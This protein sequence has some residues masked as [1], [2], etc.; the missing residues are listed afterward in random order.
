MAEEN[1]VETPAV[2]TPAVEQ[3]AAP[4]I[5]LQDLQ[6]AVKVI[7]YACE[8]GAFK[9]WA[10]IEQVIAVRNKINAFVVASTP[11]EEPK[12]EEAKKPAGK[13]K[14]AAPVKAVPAAKGAKAK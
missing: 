10:V 14:K 9:G 13:G 3:P 6:N 2:E 7:D 1:K 4:S 5:G 12:A 8:Q 11:K